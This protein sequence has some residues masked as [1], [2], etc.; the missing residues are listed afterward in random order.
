MAENKFS[1][2]DIL[3]EYPSD[4]ESPDEAALDDIL[5]SYPATK[6]YED[7]GLAEIFDSRNPTN[8]ISLSGIN[9]SLEQDYPSPEEIRNSRP[10][11]VHDI[12]EDQLTEEERIKKDKQIKYEIMSGD[13]DRKYMPDEL[14]TE[15]ELR[16]ER[17]EKEA[18]EKK[19]KK[20][21]VKPVKKRFDVDITEGIKGLRDIYD[22]EEDDFDKKYGSS[23]LLTDTD[24]IPKREK[25]E[26]PFELEQPEGMSLS[27]KMEHQDEYEEK[28]ASAEPKREHN[29]V[30]PEKVTPKKAVRERDPFDKYAD[31]NDLDSIL[32]QYEKPERPKTLA[33]SD[34]SH[35]K[36]FTDIFNKLLAKEESGG[37]GSELLEESKKIKHQNTPSAIERKKISDI[38]LDLS[39]KLIQ[40]TA[41]ISRSKADTELE[42]M[43]ALKE[44]R[45][46]KIK[47]F[48]LVG[49][50]EENTEAEVA[51]EK[52]NEEIDDFKS[53]EDAPDIE[54]HIA[55]QKGRLAGR[56]VVLFI[57]FIASTYMA[58]ANDFN[59]PV[60]ETFTLINK[61]SQPDVFLFINSVIGV[62]AGFVA[63]QTISSGIS[64]LFSMKADCD[65]L[66]AM[67]LISGLLTSMVSL[68]DSNMVRGSFVYIYIPV[69]VGALIFNTIGK[70]LIISRTQRSFSYI[71]GDN[72]RY[73][74]FIVEDE[75][76]A[77]NFTRGAL[78]DFP[79]LAGMQKTEVITDFL[80]TSYANDS[81]D[82]FCRIVSPIIAGAGLLLGI[83]SALLGISEH[84]T[85]GAVCM[86]L[87][88]FSACASIC[89][90]FSMMLVVNMPMEKASVKYNAKQ[91]AIIGFDS[92]DEFAD[93][94]S[95]MI[96]AS[97]LFPPG[98]IILRNIKSFPDTSI[99]EA[100]VEAASLTSQAGSVLKNMFYDIIVGKTEMLNPV[101]SYI[102]ED[103]M[104]L[105]GWINNKR[106]L[107]GNRELMQNHSIEG[108]PSVAKEKE[109]TGEDK[110]AVYLSISGQLSAMFIIELMPSHQIKNALKELERSGIA[111]ML[112]SVDSMLSVHRLS[113]LFEV[114]PALFRLIPFRLH[115]DFEQTTEYAAKRPATLACSGRFAS[116]AQLIIGANRLR[117]TISAGIAMQ[118]AEI[119][120]GILLT[121]TLV[122]LHSM[123]ELTV[124]NILLYNLIFVAI[125]A[126]FNAIRK[127]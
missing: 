86:G 121:L 111:V 13:Y 124:T 50:E 36:G 21:K 90:C 92:I 95:I 34:T 77:Q 100:I 127:V 23:P 44:R 4:G 45:S 125:F 12:P 110:I 10:K 82:R 123:A 83:I 61:R 43:S 3:S 56:L 54:K 94:N 42:K 115:S 65:T 118:A 71:S 101:E 9:I 126:I 68:A 31:D 5:N 20:T 38:D 99:D 18:A 102:Y 52:E 70:L 74:L 15:A 51:E 57:C 106:V 55:E 97:Q 84:G 104:G 11:S 116:F 62:V 16:A 32:S 14:K 27:E 47:D 112:R 76:K 113:E 48:V 2:E 108:L 80:K 6:N 89:S 64:K 72:D 87:S 122:L 59:L 67:A 69:A 41:Q 35:L 7:S 1:L 88:T 120:L 105:C 29:K 93:T 60:L 24:L 91:G 17:E 119:L 28:Y 96:D 109:Y 63:S 39:D 49:D 79:I 75:D 30:K 98:S 40:D 73:A 25:R 85:I 58:I 8:D 107:L 26:I 37:E 78:T 53:L 81:T 19:T 22:E 66:S 114:T 103:S 117:G 46:K 33:R